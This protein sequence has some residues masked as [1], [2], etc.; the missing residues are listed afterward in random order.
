MELLTCQLDA[1]QVEVQVPHFMPGPF[2]PMT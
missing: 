1:D 2:G